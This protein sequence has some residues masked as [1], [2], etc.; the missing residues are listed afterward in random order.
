LRARHKYPDPE[1]G[2]LVPFELRHP[3]EL[4]AIA[5][6]HVRGSIGWKPS[7]EGAEPAAARALGAWIPSSDRKRTLVLCIPESP[8]YVHRLGSVEQAQYAEVISMAAAAFERGGFPALEV[9]KG[10]TVEDYFD[11][12]HLSEQ[13]GR[14]LAGEVAPRLRRLARELG[15]VK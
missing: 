8:Y 10:Y 12:V 13:G 15:Y 4:E 11:R 3:P 6:N 7:F 14:R 9:G 2:P 5:M 1:V